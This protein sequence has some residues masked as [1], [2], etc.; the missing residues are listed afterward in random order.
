MIWIDYSWKEL[1]R[2]LSKAVTTKIQILNRLI[3]QPQ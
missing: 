3:I 2:L 1:Q